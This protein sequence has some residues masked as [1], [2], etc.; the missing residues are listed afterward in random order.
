MSRRVLLIVEDSQELASNLEI[1]LAAIAK[2]EVR[3]AAGVRQAWAILD[4]LDPG[5]FVAIITDIRLAGSDGVTLIRQLR[6]SVRFAAAPVVVVSGEADPD[7]EQRLAALD[8]GA[9]FRKPF[10]PRLLRDHVASLLPAI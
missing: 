5:D 10:S 3:V 4:R 7:L 9:F 8:V 2:T 1:A 6:D